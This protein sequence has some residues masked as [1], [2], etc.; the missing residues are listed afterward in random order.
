MHEECIY[1]VAEVGAR[2]TK[3]WGVHSLRLF[4][5]ANFTVQKLVFSSCHVFSFGPGAGPSISTGLAVILVPVRSPRT[6]PIWDG[7][8]EGCGD[9]I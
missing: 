3:H 1:T 7:G 2:A 9:Q 8:P 5:R 6:V 4:W